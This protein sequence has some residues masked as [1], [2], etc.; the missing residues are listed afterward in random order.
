MNIRDE[1]E[2]VFRLEIETLDKVRES[3]DGDYVKAAELLFRCSGKVVVT[4]VGKSGLI[5][6]KIA[7]T[8]VSTGTPALFLHPGDGL[9]G[10]VHLIP[11]ALLFL[12]TG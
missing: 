7:S 5:A 10:D 9:H 3:V 12:S 2:R 6:Q 4:G 1:I 8:M 11:F